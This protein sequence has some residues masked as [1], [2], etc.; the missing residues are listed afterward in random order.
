MLDWIKR[1]LL[2]CIVI[3]FYFSVFRSVRSWG[4]DQL[5]GTLLPDEYGVIVDNLA[6]YS[7]SS[8]SFTIYDTIKNNH[9]WQYKMPFGSFFL[10]SIIGLIAI[11]SGKEAFFQLI[12]LHVI[13]FLIATITLFIGLK[14]AAQ[15]FIVTDFISRYLIPVG[16]L[17]LVAISLMKKK[18]E[19]QRDY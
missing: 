12:G 9:G 7:Q 10:F 14:S 11:K 6:F 4:H 16:S 1:V 5:M 19:D 17:G 3:L 13:G 18:N 15:A 8:V 2:I